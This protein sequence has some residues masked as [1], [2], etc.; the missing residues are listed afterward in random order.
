VLVTVMGVREMG[1]LVGERLVHMNVPV[2]QAARDRLVMIVAVVLVVDM[3]MVVGSGLV[4]V[5][6]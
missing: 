4:S 2:P 3:P 5:L 6:M 1:M